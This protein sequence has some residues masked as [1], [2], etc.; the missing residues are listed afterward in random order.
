MGLVS[1]GLTGTSDQGAVWPSWPAETL[2]PYPEP[3]DTFLFKGPKRPHQHKDPTK[4]GFWYPLMFGP[5]ARMSDPYVYVVFW[6]S[7]LGNLF[8]GYTCHRRWDP[9]PQ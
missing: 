6:A 7:V 2:L 9:T 5:G 3:P 4:H 8:Q 1:F